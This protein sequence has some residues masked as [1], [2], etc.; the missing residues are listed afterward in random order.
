LGHGHGQAIGARMHGSAPWKTEETIVGLPRLLVLSVFS[1]FGGCH[2]SPTSAILTGSRTRPS[3][4]GWNGRFG[5]VEDRRNNHK[6]C[7]SYLYYPDLVAVTFYPV[8]FYP[9]CA[10][11]LPSQKPH[12]GLPLRPST[13]GPEP[14]SAPTGNG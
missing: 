2:L 5:L 6:A 12:G 8:T 13:E 14:S 1:R 10:L 3:D 7:E 4:W 9:R 11:A